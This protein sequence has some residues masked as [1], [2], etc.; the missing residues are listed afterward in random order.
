MHLFFS[1]N[2]RAESA[3]SGIARWMSLPRVLLFAG[4]LLGAHAHAQTPAGFSFQGNTF[5]TWT[6]P[7]TGW[8]LLDVSGG[9]GG[10]ASN[11]SYTG[12][13]GAQIQA[14]VRLTKGEVLRIAVGG[15]GGKGTGNGNNPSGGGGGGSSSIVRVKDTAAP[16]VPSI[17]DELLLIVAG[18]GGAASNY[19]GNS[20]NATNTSGDF[21]GS[22]GNGGGIGTNTQG[23]AG[24]AGYLGDGGTHS[25]G[26]TLVSYGG[27]RY[28]AGNFGGYVTGSIGG[29]GGWGGGGQGG[30]AKSGTDG[31]GGGGGG[32]SGGGGGKNPG[33]GGGGGGSFV[34]SSTANRPAASGVVRTTGAQSGNGAVSITLQRLSFQPDTSAPLSLPGAYFT[35][36]LKFPD[37][38]TGGDVDLGPG[39]T[40]PAGT[41]YAELTPATNSQSGTMVIKSIPAR[42]KVSRM[43]VK[44]QVQTTGGTTVPAEGFSFNFG[45][46]LA[47]NQPIGVDGIASGLAVT[48]DTYDGGDPDS[49]PA[50]EVVYDSLVKGGI[51]FLGSRQAGRLPPYAVVEDASGNSQSLTTGD[52]WV[53]VQVD[54]VGDLEKGGGLVNVTWNGYRILKDIPVPYLPSQ[55][56]GWRIAFGAQTGSANNQAQRVRNLS[57]AAD[58]YVTLDVISQFGSSLV[59]PPAGRRTYHTGESVTFSVPPFV[60]LDRYR[61]TLSGTEDD[62]RIRANYRAKL[63]GGSIGGQPLSGG[64]TVKLTE[65]AVVNWQWELDYLAEV[66]T[67]TETIQGL[68]ASSVT[69]ATNQPTLGRNFRPLNYNFDSVVYSQIMGTGTGLDIQFQPKGYVIEN[70]PNSPERFLQLS[71]GGDHL[72]SDNAGTG[73]IG[74]DGSFTIE[75]WARRDPV[76]ATADQNVVSLGSTDSP[77]EQLRVGFTPANAFFVGNNVAAVAAPAA[78]TDNSWHH[79]AAVN[80]KTANTVTL[81]RDGKVVASGNAALNFSGSTQTV[82]I[83]AR[84]TG[85]GTADGFFPGGINNVRVWKT[86]LAID[87]IRSGR[88]TLLVGTGNASL[89]LEL[90][91]DTLPTSDMAGVYIEQREGT[92]RPTSVSDTESFPVQASSIQSGFVLP[93]LATVPAASPS[94]Y[95]GWTLRSRLRIDVAGTYTFRMSGGDGGRLFIDG[96]RIWN[97]NGKQ[98]DSSNFEQ[99]LH[100][101][102]GDHIIVLDAYEVG[103]QR[104]ALTFAPAGT[105]L[106]PLPPAKLFALA[107]EQLAYGA[108]T[109]TSAEGGNV[110]FATAGFGSVFPEVATGAQVAAAVL[111]GFRFNPLDTTTGTTHNIDPGEKGVMAD[112]RRVFWLWD[113]KFRFTVDV[114]AVGLPEAALTAFQNHPFFKKVDG[115]LDGS[116]KQTQTAAG[117]RRVLDLWLAEGER[118][119]VGTLYRTTDRRYTFKKIS[120]AINNF[121]PIAKES[122]LN[123]TYSGRVAKS[124]LIPAVSAPGSMTVEVDRTTYRTELA[125]G[126]GLDFSSRN[127]IDTQLTP[128][129]PDDAVLVSVTT[130]SQPAV[131]AP[132]VTNDET[133]WTNGDGNPWQWDIVGQKWYPLK[134][135]TYTLDWKDRNTGEI[136]HMEVT[137]GFPATTSTLAFREDDQGN[138]LGTAPDYETDVAFDS[139][140][141]SFPASPTAHYRYIK[142]PKD[143]FPVDLDSS[144][145]DR[146]RFLRQAFSTGSTAKVDKNNASG[147]RFTETEANYK[148][149][150]VFSYRPTT[151]AATGDLT[152]EQIAVRVIG[153]LATATRES[154]APSQTVA[155]R[156][157]SA[158]DTAGYGSGYIVNEVSN[159]NATLY[160]RSAA[161]GKWGPVYPVN[162]GGLFTDDKKLSIG[163]YENPGSDPASLVNPPVG[164]PYIVTHYD[165]VKFP[166]ENDESVSVIYIASQLGSEGVNQSYTNPQPQRVFDPV[167]YTNLAVYNQPNRDLPGFNPN[168]EHA[169][170]APSNL[171]NMTG[172]QSKN[173]GQSA[174]FA[175]QNRI[176]RYDMSIKTGLDHYTSEAFVL[177][178]YVDATTGQPGMTAYRVLTT[179]GFNTNGTPLSGTEEFP[180]RDPKTHLPVDEEG[181]PVSQPANPRYDFSTVIFAGDIV[182]PFYPLNLVMGGR[183]LSQ[184][185]G[186]NRYTSTVRQ[187]TLWT[188][189]NKVPWAVA[190]EIEIPDEGTF[191]G[192]F[193]YRFWYPLAQGFWLGEGTAAKGN[194]TPVCWLPRSPVA[195]PS[196]SVFTSN[197]S[198][199]QSILY[200]SYWKENYPV[201]KRGETLA[202]AGGEYKADHPTA[203][204][205]PAVINWASGEVV[206]DSET[207]DGVINDDDLT[208][209]NAR[210]MRLLDVVSVDYA[211][212]EMPVDLNPANTAKV[213]VS[214]S[215]WYFKELSGPLSRRFYYDTLQ[216]KLV[217]RGTVNGLESGDPSLTRPPLAIAQILPNVISEKD[218]TALEQLASSDSAW[219]TAIEEL[220]KAS[221]PAGHAESMNT[222]L[223]GPPHGLRL[224]GPGEGTVKFLKEDGT[225]EEVPTKFRSFKS[226]GTGAML[227]PNPESLTEAAGEERYVTVVEN[228]DEKVNGAVTLHVIRLGDERYRGAISVITP[229]DAFD[230]KVEM[231]HSGDFGGTADE[232]YYQWWVRD[233]APLDGLQ[234]PDQSTSGWSIYQQG[235]GLNSIGFTGRPDLILAD[236]L[237]YVRYGHADEL[238]AADSAE[239]VENGGVLDSAWRL[240]DPDA[241]SPD[242]APAAS[243]ADRVPYQ[244][245]GAAN[246]PQL[247]ASGARRFVPQLLMGWVKR[248]LDAVNP[249]E[250]RFS[251][252]FTGDAPATGS[253]MLGQAGRPYNGPVA[254]N[255]SKDAIENVGLIELYE[256]VLQRAKDLTGTYSDS[257]T[258]QALLLASTRLA[259]LYELVAGEAYT[260]ALNPSISL[261]TA[262]TDNTALNFAQLSAANP[263]VFAF[264]NQVPNLLQEELALL[265]GTDYL[266]SYPCQNRLFWNYFKGIG[267][268]AYN[269]NYGIWDANRD[270]LIDETDAGLIFPMGHG[271]AWGHFLS[272]SKMHYGLLQRDNYDWQAR[273]ELYS[274]IGNVIPTD[275]LD[276]QSF[277]RTAAARARCGLSIVKATYRDAYVA[278]PSAQWQGYT[279]SADPARA[280]GVSEWASRA[281][282]GAVFDW[283]VG[284]AILPAGSTDPATGKPLEGLNLINRETAKTDL[285][286]L[287]GSLREIQQT[288]DGVNQGHTP[289]GVNPDTVS[290]GLDSFYDLTW[291]RKT[292][293]EQTYESAVAAA[294]NAKAAL[295]FVSATSQTMRQIGGDAGELKQKA[296][297]QDIDYRNRLIA[298][299]GT[300]YNGAIG[301]GQI[302]QEG[303]TG[304]DLITYTYLDATTVEQLLPEAHKTEDGLPEAFLS[305]RVKIQKSLAE[306]GSKLEF[307]PTGMNDLLLDGELM[308]LFD[309]FYLTN[310]K[311][312]TYPKIIING[313]SEGEASP[314]NTLSVEIPISKTS[315]YA[316]KAPEGWGRRAATGEIQNALGD[317]LRT[318]VALETAID[319]YQV[320][321][322]KLSNLAEYAN[323]RL[324]SLNGAQISRQS[325]LGVISAANAAKTFFETTAKTTEKIKGTISNS[326]DLGQDLIPD[327][328][329]LAG[330]NLPFR[331]LY[332]ALTASKE[333]ALTPVEGIKSFQEVSAILAEGLKA[334]L[335]LLKDNDAEVYGEFNE[336]LELLKEL[337]N[338]LQEDP[339]KRLN[340]AAAVQDLNMAGAK[341]RSLEAEANRLLAERAAMNKMIAGR[342]QGNRYGDMI[343]RISRDDAARKY[344]SAMD[345]AVRFAWLAAKAY[346]YE[347]SLSPGHPANAVTVLE[348]LMKV[349]QLG[350]WDGDTPKVGNGGLAEILAKLKANYDGLKGSIGLN[351]PQ[352]EAS[353][354][355]LRTEGKRILADGSSSSN[356][357]WQSYLAS[358]QVA[359]FNRDPDFTRHCRPFASPLG[360]AQPGFK[361][362]FSTEINS[363]RNFFGNALSAADHAYSSAN[364]ATKLRSVG[365]GFSGYDVAADGKQ[366]LAAT[367]RV[368]LVPAGTDIMRYSDGLVPKTRG[369][370]VVRQRIPVPFPINTTHL[371]DYAFNPAVESLN[372]SFAELVRQGDFRAY[373]TAG[374][375]LSG[376]D[377]AYT[378]TQLFSRS[379]WNTKW[380]L[381][382]PAASLGSEPKAAMQR[383]MDTVDDV[384]LQLTTFSSSGM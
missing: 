333:V 367:P 232:V 381:F 2:T 102:A 289:I 217:F 326:F 269:A 103:G 340:M 126:E 132:E 67:G 369:W 107:R 282:Q 81:Y 52:T 203:P 97:P 350:Q 225:E 150:L 172:D 297:E 347:T 207:P 131:T 270:G 324:V 176:N 89:G 21:G 372:G 358:T 275:Y 380:I 318:E 88:T 230:E 332:G 379:V 92:T 298:L 310:N 166:S 78:L 48:F 233:V 321:V 155:S 79:W 98:D 141:A 212:E 112:Y 221:N 69:D 283:M 366:Q 127:A 239:N 375:A 261:T 268:A 124:Y 28:V 34:F 148:T 186:T 6:V 17:N 304:P 137:A 14:S 339:S 119:E 5:Q 40:V 10:D 364:F 288:L 60:Y 243:A 101:G 220:F 63:V 281:G 143:P 3:V 77:G 267:E 345:T 140:D 171:A 299:L 329:N 263:Y 252:D 12:G 144:A 191:P 384:Q 20:G 218:K 35:K 215:R 315:Q 235:K 27:Q 348:D 123:A 245:A 23:G 213:S 286:A 222:P 323:R 208:D 80:D 249:Y 262:D 300:P 55:S 353:T 352:G 164:W 162:W 85:A 244:W 37:D 184:N 303:Y 41:S 156:I 66:N 50:V 328:V 226:L 376:S 47:A 125:I 337:S 159:Y 49:A 130:N 31:G 357:K 247:Q 87:Q 116:A 146:W 250:A 314:G 128:D 190:G 110:S 157:G 36:D 355:S 359:D 309:E 149:V 204:G 82:T 138:Y 74:G 95:H 227:V 105:T 26:G 295:D 273:A 73:L 231:A 62:M 336:L 216:A 19:G 272:A 192:G 173:I 194:G 90:P 84:A 265:R 179:R 279:D 316:F 76:A 152:R 120:N 185:A 196:L 256:T 9:Q 177:G 182:A 118:L 341:V 248:V 343:A 153:S 121:S 241:T 68:S 354:L 147:P 44:F 327:N 57:L 317:M 168:E 139:T 308:K 206:F 284:N 53:P 151:G 181:N 113:K 200:S 224:A 180:N 46:D 234:T 187:Q 334:E 91:F 338:E 251:A 377:P 39:V 290:F 319:D 365:V 106:Q 108:F 360:P 142:S 18:G 237:F 100:L 160:D 145:A 170:V 30:P 29:A 45:P 313:F 178:Q 111:P 312:D 346:D 135:G 259:M 330:G 378:D 301:A 242:W 205:L 223:V 351:N 59:S 266:K 383:F 198:T 193:E 188:D 322:N 370:N 93:D 293:F 199:P 271:D 287:A 72:R 294:S 344:E 114:M 11:G 373:P 65:S 163:Y 320:Y 238:A 325:Y 371:R 292:H 169:L 209:F 311:Q 361:I 115:V 210:F 25:D 362:E 71:G 382:I 56:E 167:Q 158:D 189:K 134:P 296:I 51:S 42:Q 109:T 94:G 331:P 374:G 302:F 117:I 195:N 58:T 161:V 54:L 64:S 277:A 260:D 61:K 240:V 129:L 4:L 99:S 202:Y 214:G 8:Y 16:L 342:A 136:Y 368:Y 307:L 229:K 38:I 258:N 305:A 280:W 291:E 33:D 349:R 133:G 274:L 278:D 306:T 253:S 15:Q 246:S 165:D 104:P 122:L 228:N 70:A 211:K 257:G 255:G 183:V 174:F 264:T 24:G 219:K 13:K 154:D 22:N 197:N 96:N 175:L 1:A 236:K 356:Q 285:Q 43:V 363:G 276:E 83:G 32:Y 201:L 7:E 254:L 335:E 75:F 86:A